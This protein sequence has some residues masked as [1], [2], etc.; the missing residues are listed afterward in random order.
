MELDPKYYEETDIYKEEVNK[1]TDTK[2]YPLGLAG[3]GKSSLFIGWKPKEEDQYVFSDGKILNIKFDKLLGDPKF[4]V[5]SMFAINR[6]AYENQIDLIVDYMNFYITFYDEDREFVSSYLKVKFELDKRQRFSSEDSDAFFEFM[7]EMIITP[8]FLARITRMVNDCYIDDIEGSVDGESKYTKDDSKKHLESLEFTNQHVKILLKISHTM[9]LLGPLI[10][11]Y[12]HLNVIKLNKNSDLIYRAFKPLFS[13]M[14]ED[15]NIYNKIVVYTRAKVL[16][17]KAHNPLM[18]DKREIFGNDESTLITSLV[19]YIIITN[20]L[21]KLKFPDKWDKKQNKFK[22]NVVGFLK[23]VLKF[24]LGY[25][26]KVKLETNL[27]E[28]TNSSSTDG[29][30]DMD[31]MMSMLSKINEG[32][33]VL[34]SVNCQQTLE[35]IRKNIDIPVTADEIDYYRLHHKPSA[36]QVQLVSSFWCKY[37]GSYRDTYNLTRRDYIYIAVLLRKML[38]IRSGHNPNAIYDGSCVLP[39]LLTGNVSEKVNMRVIRN[40]KFISKIAESDAYKF[41]M[42]DKYSYLEEI[43]PNA[44]LTILS[45]MI[46]TRFTLVSYDEPD[47]LG[48]EIVYNEDIISDEM[49]NFISL[50]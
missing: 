11:Q 3:N 31:K 22:E 30:S 42:E 25:F 1:T 34:S 16:E 8:K 24:Q 32:D 47:N 48:E 17:S 28:V 7:Y 5:Y 36:F 12:A 21:F 33:V 41:I 27:T 20:N 44:I 9:K 38:L 29:L 4:S 10:F 40:N 50:I 43:Q 18:Y 14:S 6:T 46:N 13:I 39:F 45:N 37:F 23:T 26:V 49:L 35:Y 2:G 19:S 15:V